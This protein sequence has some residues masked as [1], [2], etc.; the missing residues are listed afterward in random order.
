MQIN[1]HLHECILK[2]NLNYIKV[3][4]LKHININL[5]KI[6]INISSI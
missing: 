3:K 4:K 1:I 5:T 6:L 2:E